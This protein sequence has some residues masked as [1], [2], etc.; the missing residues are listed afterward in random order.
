MKPAFAKLPTLADLRREPVAIPKTGKAQRVIDTDAEKKEDDK[1]LLELRQIVWKRDEGKCR[2]CKK[3][4]IKSLEASPKRGEVAHIRSRRFAATRYEPRNCF[5]ACYVCHAL[6]D[7]HL[8]VVV[9]TATFEIDGAKYI[10]ANEKLEF[11][12]Q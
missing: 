12:R 3:R 11:I 10:N 7:Q 8:L 6:V 4:V 9:G 5:L 1:R 2:A